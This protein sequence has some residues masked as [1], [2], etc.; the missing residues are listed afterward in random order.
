MCGVH[1]KTPVTGSITGF[2]TV[3]V[4][5]DDPTEPIS[6]AVRSVADG[7]VVLSR[8]LAQAGHW[9]AVE[10]LQSVSRVM[11]DVTDR[12]HQAAVGTV[13]AVLADYARI[14]D[15]VTLGAYRR[16]SDPAADRA[17]AAI[18]P[19]REFLAQAVDAP[20]PFSETLPRL[21]ALQEQ[22]QDAP[23]RGHDAE[24]PEAGS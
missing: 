11:A 3:L 22:V 9:P 7:H 4:E 19:V 2:Y 23:I 16:G 15:L 12:R 20:A 24:P 17:V 5:D 8:A 1:E 14:E 13:R 6:D 21:L 18:G 10:C